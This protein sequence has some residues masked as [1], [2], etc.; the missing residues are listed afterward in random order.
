[1]TRGVSGGEGDEGAGGAITPRNRP[2]QLRSQKRVEMILDAAAEILEHE[3]PDALNTNRIARA[4]GVPVASLY[5]YFPNKHAILAALCERWLD[6]VVAAINAA[7][8]RCP[9]EAGLA[10]FMDACMDSLAESYLNTPGLE[11]LMQVMAVLPELRAIEDQHDERV[12]G[13]LAGLL[14]RGGIGASAADRVLISEI[15]LLGG[16]PLLVMV[17]GKSEAERLRAFQEVKLLWR[18]YLKTHLG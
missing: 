1:M 17:R 7:E 18:S 5:H 3:G 9:P 13:R 11:S 16:H 12:V 4:S 15:L 10:A 6:G 2:T 8:A 14:G